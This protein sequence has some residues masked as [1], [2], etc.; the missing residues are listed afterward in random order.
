MPAKL[1]IFIIG[2]V[3]TYALGLFILRFSKKLKFLDRP[4]EDRKIQP[5]AVPYGGGLLIFLGILSQVLLGLGIYILFQE[6]FQVWFPGVHFDAVLNDPKGLS[7]FLGSIA[8]L[9]LGGVDDV[10]QLSP[11][12]KLIVQLSV[13]AF[14]LWWGKMSMSFFLPVPWIGFLG[15]MFWVVLITNAFNLIDNMD[16]YCGGVSLVVLGLH[17]ILLNQAGHLMVELVCC[18]CFASLLGFMWYNKPPAK[19][20]LGDSGSYFLGF[21]ISMLSVLSTYYRDGQSLAGSLT[22][23]LILAVPLFDV[24]TVLWIRTKLKKSWF[25]GDLN[26]FS[27]RLLDLG[28]SPAQSLGLILTL[29]LVCGLGGLMLQHLSELMAVAVFIQV[30]IILWVI[31]LLERASR[32]KSLKVSAPDE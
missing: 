9:I 14:V 7:I 23:I 24:A 30:L 25:K 5:K 31:H 6:T 22:P 11:R 20:Y 13:T 12:T 28:L 19:L 17:I 1:I 2:S 32:S 21:L 8:M 3:L 29:S 16:G 10:K 27:H 26:H 18:A 4:S 15:T